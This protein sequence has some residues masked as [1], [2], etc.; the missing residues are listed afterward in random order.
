MLSGQAVAPPHEGPWAVS[1]ADHP[2][3]AGSPLFDGQGLVIG[4]V[5]A[6]RD[7]LKNHLPAVTL[8]QL[9]EFLSSHAAL[10]AAPSGRPDPMNVL[11][12]T[13]QEN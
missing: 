1:L 4:V 13:V 7:D 12:V 9:R 11:E 8:A 5:I 2:R 10:P 6:K 3:L